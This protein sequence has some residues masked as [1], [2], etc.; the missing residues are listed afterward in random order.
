M[1]ALT[2][3]FAVAI[4]FLCFGLGVGLWGGSVAEVTRLAGVSASELGAAF[5]GFA[6]AGIFGMAVSGKIAGSVSLKN[7]LIILLGLTAVCLAALLHAPNALALTAGLFAF[8]FL[9]ASVDLVMN[10]EGVAVEADLGRPVLASFHAWSSIGLAA[11]AIAGSW[12]SVTLGVNATSLAGFAVYGCAMA[13][14]WGVT[15]LRGATQSPGGGAGWFRPGMPLIL[16]GLLV[17]A[18]IS[19]ELSVVM[20]SSNT[21]AA[22]APDL[23]ALAGF[24]ATLYAVLQGGVRFA[25]DRL[26]AALG[27]ERLIA[28]S[29]AIVTVGL[30]VVALAAAGG[31][32]AQAVAGF[33][34]I[35]IGTACIVPAG[36]ALSPRFAGVSAVMAISMLSII[37]APFRVISPL[38]YGEAAEQF[39]F[40][41]AYGVFGLLALLALGLAFLMLHKTR[42]QVTP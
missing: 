34:L 18:C 21:L 35:G 28:I 15:P 9:G 31:G 32:F 16:L 33:A 19:V 40:S 5:V 42:T 2:P 3:R 38:A 4:T 8:S 20:F 25:G 22:L 13:V 7:R 37:G 10:A 29:L 41:P 39:G 24:G 1:T 11:G 23:A 26:R 17:G 14:V 12:L 27:D 30:L 36:F 6:V